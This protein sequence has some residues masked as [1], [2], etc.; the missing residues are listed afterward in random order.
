MFNA[1]TDDDLMSSNL[2]MIPIIY[3]Y[4]KSSFLSINHACFSIR[5][6]TVHHQNHAHHQLD[7]T[8]SLPS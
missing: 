4:P 6:I 3:Q 8:S 5:A 2:I 1:A 7:K